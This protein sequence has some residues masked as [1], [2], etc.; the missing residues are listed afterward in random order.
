MMMMMTS[1]PGY[2]NL[3]ALPTNYGTTP[4][5]TGSAWSG[6]TT[7]PTPA[8][9]VPTT[10]PSNTGIPSFGVGQFTDYNSQVNQNLNQAYNPTYAPTSYAANSEYNASTYAPTSLS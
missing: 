5:N 9:G 7:T 1:I 3:P 8:Y 2:G 6:A 4:T 10:T